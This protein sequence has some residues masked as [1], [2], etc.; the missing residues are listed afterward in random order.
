MRLSAV[1]SP[2]LFM[3]SMYSDTWCEG[4]DPARLLKVTCSVLMALVASVAKL[5][6]DTD[7]WQW[8]IDDVEYDGWH[9]VTEPHVVAR[10]ANCVL[11]DASSPE[12]VKDTR[13]VFLQ[14]CMV[15]WG[16]WSYSVMSI[17]RSA[18]VSRNWKELREVLEMVSV[19][20]VRFVS[21]VTSP[22]VVFSVKACSF[23]RVQS[24]W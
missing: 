7:V 18:V 6:D 12:R 1:I 23:W 2:V 10:A 13:S 22:C 8:E 19:P 3:Y 4:T 24:A 9:I 5:V 16:P 11:H 15:M 21:T 17:S 20:N 14:N